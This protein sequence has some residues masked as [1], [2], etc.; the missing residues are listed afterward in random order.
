[1]DKFSNLKSQIT[2]YVLEIVSS[3]KFV[4]AKDVIE[5]FTE[6]NE[7][8]FVQEVLDNYDY[9]G[10]FDVKY[11][12]SGKLRGISIIRDVKEPARRFLRECA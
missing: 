12:K 6:N 4:T 11:D 1:M 8:Q 7:S 10:F 2:R 3:N 5:H 9:E